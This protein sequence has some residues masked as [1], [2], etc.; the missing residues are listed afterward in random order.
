[1]KKPSV[2]VDRRNGDRRTDPDPCQK[3]PIDLY[4]RK[5]RKASERRGDGKTLVDDYY[6]VTDNSDARDGPRTI[7]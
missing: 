1:M 2:F 6:A 7:D 3:M 4:H 5:R